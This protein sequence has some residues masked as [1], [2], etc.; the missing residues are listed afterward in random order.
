MIW[1]I[2]DHIP[3]ATKLDRPAMGY[4]PQPHTLIG[5]A[6]IYCVCCMSIGSETAIEIFNTGVEAENWL[7][8]HCNNGDE[9]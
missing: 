8:T 1:A 6:E 9:A 7:S 4:S 2:F 3:D 5:G